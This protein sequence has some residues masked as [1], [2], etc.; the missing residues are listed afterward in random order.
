M[1]RTVAEMQ[2]V[3][4]KIG[5]SHAKQSLLFFY[6]S[7]S[8]T[9]LELQ[10]VADELLLLPV[11][12]LELALIVGHLLPHHARRVASEPLP[13]ACQLPPLLPIIVE[14]T[15][16]IAQL[17]IL[18]RQAVDE[19]LGAAHLRLQLGRFTLTCRCSCYNRSRCCCNG[20]G[21]CCC[22]C[23]G[24]PLEFRAGRH[25]AP[26]QFNWAQ[27]HQVFTVVAALSSQTC[28]VC[29][30]ITV[31]GGG[32]GGGGCCNG[33]HGRRWL[34]IGR[35]GRMG[36]MMVVVKEV[37]KSPLRN[38]A[39]LWRTAY[40]SY[41]VMTTG[42]GRWWGRLAGRCCPS[43]TATINTAISGIGG[44]GIVAVVLFGRG[45]WWW[46]TDVVALLLLLI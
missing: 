36:G 2:V 12:L 18:C 13:L 7:L 42:R 8:M 43:A 6:L 32:G 11:Q 10:V 16:Q 44:W 29:L 45:W 15:A 35:R 25:Q 14:E 33:C 31:V 20:G 23:G 4:I 17:L 38:A 34:V 30:L 39:G 41:P 40:H 37:A 27:R 24:Q 46:R 26:N 22:R 5:R 1:Q 3:V 28:C 19:F 9:H 21:R